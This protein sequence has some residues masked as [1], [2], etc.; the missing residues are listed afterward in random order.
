MAE[1]EDELEDNSDDEKHLFRA[2]VRAGGK[3][4]QKGAKEAKRK[5]DPT[6]KTL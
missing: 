1:Y 3:V 4:K 5:G 6:G 2:E